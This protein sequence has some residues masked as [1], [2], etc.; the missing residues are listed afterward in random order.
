MYTAGELKCI[1]GSQYFYEKMKND[2]QKIFV[3][4]TMYNFCELITQSVLISKIAEI[5]LQG[6]SF[7]QCTYL[8][9]NFLIGLPYRVA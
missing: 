2:H 8:Q 9:N 7:R 5:M 6:Q 1:V 4:I 3:R